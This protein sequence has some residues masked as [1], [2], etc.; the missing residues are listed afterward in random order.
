MNE[1]WRAVPGFEGLYEVSDL[2]RVRSL[3]RVVIC[4]GPAKGR[5]ASKKPGRVLRPGPTGSGHLSVSLGRYAG[6]RL[7]HHLVAEA[8]IGSRP[9]GK[10]LR[11]LNGHAND[12]RLLNLAYGTRSQNIRDKK[13]HPHRPSGFVLRLPEIRAIKKGLREG[14]KG[15]VLSKRYGVAES[16]VSAIKHGRFHTDV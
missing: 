2:G 1:E 12:N 9:P 14:E 5:Y 7:V 16:T 3:D 4:S 10:E 6:S 15:S 8:F 11:H 13:W